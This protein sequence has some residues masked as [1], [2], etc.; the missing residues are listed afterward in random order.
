MTTQK[1]PAKAPTPPAEETAEGTAMVVLPKATTGLAALPD[2][3]QALAQEYGAAGLEDMTQADRSTPFLALI[4]S[5]S[6]QIKPGHE[7][8]I[9]GAEQ[10]NSFNTITGELFS[11]ENGGVTIVPVYYEKTWVRWIPRDNGGG[12]LGSYKD[13]EATKPIFIPQIAADYEGPSNMVETA[14]HYVL[15]KSGDG[16]WAPAIMTLKSTQLKAS[17]DLNSLTTMVSQ[18][19]GGVPVFVKNYVL[20][21]VLK[22]N[23]M[24]EF[25]VYK[26]TEGAF[27]TK[28]LLKQAKEFRD[29]IEAGLVS[30]DPTKAE[31]ETATPE[32]EPAAAPD[33]SRPKF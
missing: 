28:D 7:K 27:V 24:G 15:V 12:F 11:N 3:L 33:P 22:K 29:A 32:A 25:Y 31:T 26:V 16:T 4:Q 30:V 21:S 1:T 8:Q 13:E 18:K 10:G 14:N 23:D 19:F 2:D 20:V 5:N 9:K 6:P 17:R